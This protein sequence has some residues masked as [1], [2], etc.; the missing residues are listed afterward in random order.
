[1]QYFPFSAKLA[2]RSRGPFERPGGGSKGR[3]GG[4]PVRLAQSRLPD[5]DDELLTLPRY[6]RSALVP[7]VV[8]IGVGGFHRAHQA[9]YFD[10]I[11]TRGISQEWGLTGVGL[12]SPG[13]GEALGTQDNLYTVLERSDEC[14]KARVIGV[15]NRYVFAQH[16]PAEV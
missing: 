12:H 8:H 1:M 2:V 13:M 7:A 11:A 5:L 9:V 3:P 15:L 14:D 4:S 16:S 6:D 10:E